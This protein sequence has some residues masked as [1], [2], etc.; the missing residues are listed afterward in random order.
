MNDNSMEAREK[1]ID[2][3][4]LKNEKWFNLS[5]AGNNKNLKK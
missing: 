2:N 4:Q 1:R 3:K 5:I